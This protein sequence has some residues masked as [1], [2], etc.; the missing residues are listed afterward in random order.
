MTPFDFRPNNLTTRSVLVP[1]KTGS[2]EMSVQFAAFSRHGR[3][4][5][6]SHPLESALNYLVI[7]VAGQQ[8]NDVTTEQAEATN[9]VCSLPLLAYTGCT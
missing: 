6:N 2:S 9:T 8:M 4:K 5:H 7:Q 1:R 3:S